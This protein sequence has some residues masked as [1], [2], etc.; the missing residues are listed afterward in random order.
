M[1]RTKSSV[2]PVLAVGV[3]ILGVAGCNTVPEPD[4][5]QAY[6]HETNKGLK[7]QEARRFQAPDDPDAVTPAEVNRAFAKSP[8]YRPP[9]FGPD[10]TVEAPKLLHI[11]WPQYPSW[12]GHEAAQALVTVAA[13]IG[14]DGRVIEARAV[15]STN[16]R[17][18]E[19]AIEAVKL[20]TF[21]AGKVDGEPRES[22]FIVPIEVGPQGMHLREDLMS[23]SYSPFPGA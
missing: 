23:A 16:V 10:Q 20:W 3:L 4:P 21:A 2:W 8:G 5:E 12:A 9:I 17:L 1:K 7:E 13:R 15:R 14:V 19:P 22:V 18:N 11:E 6:L